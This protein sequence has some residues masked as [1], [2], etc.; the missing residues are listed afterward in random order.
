LNTSHLLEFPTL[1]TEDYLLRRLQDTDAE[2]IFH[3]FSDDEVTKYY[4]F[5]T[6]KHIE[7]AVRFISSKE[8]LFQEGRGIRWGITTKDN[9]S[10]VIGTIGFHNWNKH[11]HKAE[12]GYEL[13]K[14]FWGQG[15][16]SR[17]LPIVIQYGFHTME[18]NRIEALF[19]P[20]NIGSRKVLE[21]AGFKFEGI[22]EEY[23]LIKG[24]FLDTAVMSLLKKYYQGND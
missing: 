15:V 11:S 2:A 17:L 12:V 1:E 21:K 22:L 16:M 20:D 5:N 18:L 3:Y 10:K 19:H 14:E 8:K 7:E 23:V 9:P 24:N 4:D 6:Y 13:S